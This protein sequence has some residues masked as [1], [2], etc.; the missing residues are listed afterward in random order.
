MSDINFSILEI[1]R[2]QCRPGHAWQLYML[3]RTVIHYIEKGKGV[4]VCDGKTYRLKAGNAFYIP[5]HTRGSYCADENDPWQYTWIYF[6][7]SSGYKFYEKLGLST[8]AP[9]YTTNDCGVVNKA[10]EQLIHLLEAG[11]AYAAMSGLYGLFNAMTVSNSNK[12]ERRQKIGEEYITACT[13]YIVS[14]GCE[15][16]SVGDLCKLVKIDRT[17]LYRL[18]K[19][20]LNVGPK[21][22]IV[23]TKLEMAKQLLTQSPLSVSDVAAMVGYED[24][25]AFSK[26]FKLH[27][28]ISPRIYGNKCNPAHMSPTAEMAEGTSSFQRRL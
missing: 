13:N 10:V 28:G 1:G 5:T 18:F 6:G 19:E 24:P 14:K 17:Y 4:Y 7:G 12:V 16:I 15:K 20:H 8:R 27:F 21:E 11:E 22:Y 9:V 3:D 2:E 25:F 26:Q 23:N